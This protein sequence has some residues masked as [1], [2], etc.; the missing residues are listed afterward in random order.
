MTQP[1]YIPLVFHPNAAEILAADYPQYKPY[2]HLIRAMAAGKAIAMSSPIS[3]VWHLYEKDS[4]YSGFSFH[5]SPEYYSAE[6]CFEQ[7]QTT[8]KLITL[9]RRALAA[10]ELCKK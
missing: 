5:Y 10:I 4:E 7:K 9:K 2:K 8:I 1:T 6:I 3:S